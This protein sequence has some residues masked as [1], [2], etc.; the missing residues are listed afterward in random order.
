MT[1]STLKKPRVPKAKPIE[2]RAGRPP[3]HAGLPVE[4]H[5]LAQL[6][7]PVRVRIERIVNQVE[8]LARTIDRW[9]AQASDSSR[10]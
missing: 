7:A 6:P 10:P 2:V 4:Q 3:K 1:T 5:A 9:L 8:V